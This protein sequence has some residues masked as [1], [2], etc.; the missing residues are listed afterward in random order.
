[1]IKKEQL[2]KL[3]QEFPEEFSVDELLDRIVLLSKIER[4]LRQSE[5]GEVL[6]DE[7]AKARMKAWVAS[8]SK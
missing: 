5:R 8:K 4:G 3:L 1:M 2:L 7:Q 6:T